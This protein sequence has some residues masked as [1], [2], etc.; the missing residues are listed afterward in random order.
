MR[1]ALGAFAVVLVSTS[2]LLAQEQIWNLSRDI[3]ST[4]NQISFDQGAN[5]VW[6]FMESSS[7]THD[8]LTYRLLGHYGVPCDENGK[9]GP[10]AVRGLACWSSVDTD[11]SRGENRAPAVTFNF[12]AKTVYLSGYP[13]V[14]IPPKTV[15]IDPTVAKLGIV[16]WKSPITGTILIDGKFTDLHLGG[17]T[18]VRW[19]VDKVKTSLA[20]G[21]LLQGGSQSFY[22]PSVTVSSG[23]VLYFIIDAMEDQDTDEIALS[24]RI[25]QTE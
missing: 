4:G 13:E 21:E 10:F 6:Y 15:V 9:N 1:K 8:P 23:Q 20:H 7:T 14:G 22:I 2:V 18:G 19:S 3:Q 5:G 11:Y 25:V 12:T 24:V 17:P 16:A